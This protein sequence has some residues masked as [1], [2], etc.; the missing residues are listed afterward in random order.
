MGTILQ[1]VFRVLREMGGRARPKALLERAEPR[2]NLTDFE[3]H[4]YEKTGYVRWQTFVRYYSI[5][6]QKAGYLQKSGG[7]WTL[8][9]EGI[10]A[11]DR[12]PEGFLRHANQAYRAWKKTQS[13]TA[14]GTSDP[15]SELPETPKVIQQTAYEQAVE[16]ARQEIEDHIDAPGPYDFQKLVAELLIAMSYYVPH[17]AAPGPDGGVDI[18]A[19]KDPLGVSTPRIKVQ[20]KH[21]V[22]KVTVKEVREL[23]ALLGK[24]GDIGLLVSSGGF[25]ADAEREVRS[26][27]KHIETI[28]MDRLI[29]LWQQHYDQLREPGKAWLPLV[30]VHFLA[31]TE[32]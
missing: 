16:L 20:V 1:T 12:P 15:P 24:E 17:V 18:V 22:Q 25:T 9:E 11:L 30:K 13:E 32:E 8:S 31:P 21:R 4:V 5:D 27:A 29:E 19:Y 10:K 14:P 28:D 3:R 23:V 2:L 26:S 7:Y 6:C